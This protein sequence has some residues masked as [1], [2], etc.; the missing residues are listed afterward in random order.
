MDCS[1]LQRVWDREG[2]GVCVKGRRA[3]PAR[4]CFLPRDR[5]PEWAMPLHSCLVLPRIRTG[6]CLAPRL[7][8]QNM[9]SEPLGL[10]VFVRAHVSRG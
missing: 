2:S 7:A 10:Q 8:L 5:S 3:T 4:L 1:S 9:G 6:S